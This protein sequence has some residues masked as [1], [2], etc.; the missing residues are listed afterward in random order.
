MGA[1]ASRAVSKELMDLP[2]ADRTRLIRTVRQF[3][4]INRLFSRS[5]AILRRFVVEANR[6]RTDPISIV[7]VGAGGADIM[8]RLVAACRN[9]GL[10]IRVTCLDSDERISE[11]AETQ[12]RPFP[13]I[14]VRCDDVRR[15]GRHG[16]FDYV[17]C[18]NFLHHFTNEA[19][20]EILSVMYDA[21]TRAL[22][23]S[24]ICRS[25]WAYI[26]FT[27]YASCFLH[28]SFAGYDGRLSIRKGFLKEELETAAR[29]AGMAEVAETTTLVPARLLLRV[30]KKGG[31]TTA[32]RA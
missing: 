12:C 30:V 3:D 24:D 23:V 17:F 10:P 21:A 25:P 13:E 4:T 1:F 32:P 14:S 22:L 20:P 31:S 18:N 29:E 2:D 6:D 7:D 16:P 15:L 28:R 27:L 26:G 8:R 19:I 9:V 5:G 11:F